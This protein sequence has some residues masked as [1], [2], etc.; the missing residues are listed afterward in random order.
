MPIRGDEGG[1]GVRWPPPLLYIAVL[2]VG[3]IL[4][5]AFPVPLL[6][7]ATAWIVG[8][9]VTAAGIAVGP[10]WGIPTLHRAHT[11]VR[12]DRA[13]TT[14]VTDGPFRYSRNP[15]YL[16][17]TLIYAGIAII[18]GSLWAL[19]LLIPVV[20]FM[21]LFV[22]RREEA[23]LERAFGEEYVRYRTRVRRWL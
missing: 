12:P 23:H 14:L 17:L 2:A 22:I 6:P 15:L 18:A 3:I 19:L 10:L 13:A 16:S 11:T 9:I 8:G 20:A 5:W 4:G 1:P 7:P 21:S